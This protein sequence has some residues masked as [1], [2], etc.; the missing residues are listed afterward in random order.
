[1]ILPRFSRLVSACVGG[2]LL[3]GSGQAY[4]QKALTEA[5][6]AYKFEQYFESAKLY[7]KALG[8]V[9]GAK[10]GEVTFK[11]A[12]SYRLSGQPR[13]AEGWYERAISNG[14]NEPS[15]VLQYADILKQNANYDKAIQEYN[16]YLGAKP[17]DKRG[18]DGVA[19]SQTA[20][21]YIEHPTRYKV[22][23]F[24]VM[25][26]DKNDF[27]PMFYKK[28]GLVFGSSRDEATGKRTYDRTG[29]KFT[30]L[31]IAYQ[32]KKGNWSK[33][34]M[35]EGLVNTD[36]H[37]GSPTFSKNGSIM[38]FTG[39]D[40]KT[41]GCKVYMS[42]R[43]GTG[44]DAPQMIP[45]FGKDS[46][47]VVGSPVLSDDEKSLYFVAYNAPG[48]L[49]GHDIWVVKKSKGGWDDPV[50]L[51]PGVNTS[52]EEMTPYITK[53]NM[54]Y[55]S[56][57]G[58]LGMGGL[59]V[60]SAKGQGT[61]WADVQNLKYPINSPGDDMNF[62][63]DAKKENGYVVSNREGAR[64]YD[65]YT[66]V[67]PPLVYAVAGTIIDDSTKK[68]IAGANV[69][70]I[71]PDSTYQE[72]T[73]KTNGSYSFKIKA[74]QDY[75][76][77]ANRNKYFGNSGSVSTKNEQE[78]KNYTV[79]INLRPIPETVITLRDILYD[80]NSAA[81]KDE[82]KT[83]LDQMVGLLKNTPNLRVAIN[84]HTDS[85]GRAD[86]NIALSQRRALSVVRYL[87]ANGI[88]SARLV[89][90][91]YGETKLLNKCADGV[92]C[93]EE[94][95]AVNR[96][97]EFEILSSDYK[98]KIIYKRVTGNDDEVN[99]ETT[100]A[101]DVPDNGNNTGNTPPKGEKGKTTPKG[102]STPKK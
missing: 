55:F 47:I 39:C 46:T 52:G 32:D 24:S 20:K 3:L 63:I 4:A 9:K 101:D 51:G 45:L 35:L 27:S 81:L 8:K 7:Q 74:D 38:Y 102:G 91:G 100:P 84:S 22:T 85:R 5:D 69:Q 93:T 59:D 31:W 18:T 12:E 43:Q 42:K 1:M 10:K 53:D 62:V 56:S 15:V 54:L 34:T 17:G 14:Y 94:E 82:S 44:W 37:E 2:L 61:T 76:L 11:V 75:R 48:G 78:S 88:D 19:S 98:G 29:E 72:V 41:G 23:N 89:A 21:A 83:S 26:S 70:L 49:G 36:N 86:S 97:T 71:L 33:P 28:N 67:L 73:T 92:E 68:P 57:N 40:R 79:D 30:D 77:V 13:Q 99:T 90:K 50:N 80:L 16:A 96:R 60:F 66:V 58:H 65:L 6:M 87:T 64:M 95:H 25:N